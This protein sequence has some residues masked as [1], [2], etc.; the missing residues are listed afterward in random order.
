M[1][2]GTFIIVIGPTGS[3]KSTLMK[4]GMS[5]YPE[6]T[7][8]YS[9]TTRARR[10]DHIENDHYRFLSAEEFTQKIGAGEFL[11]WAEYGGN[12]YGT[13]KAE[14][15]SDLEAGQ[16]LLKEVEV[17]GARQI[18]ELLPKEQLVTVFI[19]AGPWKELEE[20]VRAR[21]P[22]SE[23]ELEKR[24]QRYED[25]LTFM[26]EADVVI[27]NHAGMIE[28]ADRAFADLLQSVIQRS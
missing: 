1:K 9:Y 10:A 4:Y 12:Y 16:V 21:A 11:E 6:L 25:E 3:G 22:I 27:R 14:V 20:R 26:S 18:R 24:K 2:Q 23:E 28:E 7:I 5:L 13:L 8:P 15:M 17:Q 19:D